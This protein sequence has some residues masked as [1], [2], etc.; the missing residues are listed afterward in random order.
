[1]SLAISAGA[2]IRTVLSNASAC[3]GLKRALL[4]LENALKAYNA[5]SMIPFLLFFEKC[6]KVLYK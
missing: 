5:F 4:I 3:Q 1:M 6:F 2:V